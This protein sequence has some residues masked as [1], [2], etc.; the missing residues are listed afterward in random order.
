MGGN[1]PSSILRAKLATKPAILLHSGQDE[2]PQASTSSIA[3]G[4]DNKKARV[5]QHLITVFSNRY[6]QAINFVRCHISRR[7]N[8]DMGVF[9]FVMLKRNLHLR[10]G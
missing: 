3:D 10:L 2:K 1:P 4:A 5:E 6:L 8:I 7:M 9:V